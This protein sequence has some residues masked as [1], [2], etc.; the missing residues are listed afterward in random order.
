MQRSSADLYGPVYVYT[1]NDG[2][3]R[4][5]VMSLMGLCTCTLLRMD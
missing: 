1:A 4:A 5:V 3:G 2:L